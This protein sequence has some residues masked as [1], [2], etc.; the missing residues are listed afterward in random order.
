MKATA[1]GFS[2]RNIWEISRCGVFFVLFYVYLWFIVKP[3]LIY[4]GGGGITNFPVFYKGWS[5]FESMVLHPGG[6]VEYLSAFLSQFLY[7]SWAGALVLTLHALAFY[8]CTDSILKTIAVKKLRIITFFV[9]VLLLLTYNKYTYHFTTTTA[10]LAALAFTACYLRLIPQKI[11]HSLLLFLVLSALL[12]FIAGE[13][14]YLVFAFICGVYE[15]FYKRRWLVG[16]FDFLSAVVLSYVLG[17]LVFNISVVDVYSDL[18]PFSW[19]FL[20]FSQRK[21]LIEYIYALYLF[22]P[23]VVLVGGLYC[24]LGGGR[25]SS[26][27][28]NSGKKKKPKKLLGSDEMK[29]RL[30]SPLVLETVLL[31]VIA[32]LVTFF[33]IDKQRKVLFETDYYAY[34]RQWDKI[35]QIAPPFSTNSYIGHNLILASYHLGRLPSELFSYHQHPKNLVLTGGGNMR[36]YWRKAGVFY[37]LGAVNSAECELVEAMQICGPRPQLL[38]RLAVV[39]LAK[40]DFDSA[41]TYLGALS[42]TLFYSKWAET[43]LELIDSDPTL[44][45]DEEVQRLRNLMPLEDNAFVSIPVEE[46]FYSCLERNRNNK[47]AFEYLMAWYMFTKN[48]E[49][50]VENIGRL[51]DFYHQIPKYYEQALLTYMYVYK[52]QVKVAGYEISSQSKNLFDKFLLV[53]GKY[54]TNKKAAFAELSRKFGDTYFFYYIYAFLGTTR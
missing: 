15:I 26:E 3:E 45:S 53:A 6:L 34:T 41:E 2:G 48:L 19:R 5:F 21:L 25:Y 49:K 22:V 12:Y 28:S 27:E 52:K 47:M 4:H 20:Y 24:L 18:L 14:A 51:K 31:F 23:V 54:G 7:Y 42:Q 38:E 40:G 37:E 1:T 35:M 17:V 13:V 46:I 33:S 36:Q 50:F 32:F 8:I 30:K 39:R 43:Y 9:P 11:L 10:L 16:I 44:A 29:P